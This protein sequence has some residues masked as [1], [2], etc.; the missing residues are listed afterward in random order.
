MA[1]P[2]ACCLE[3]L[4]ERFLLAG[5]LWQSLPVPNP[6][7]L[8]DQRALA[9]TITPAAGSATLVGIDIAYSTDGASFAGDSTAAIAETTSPHSTLATAQPLPE[10][11]A[12]TILGSF[13]A[14]RTPA[15]FQVP[16]D[17]GTSS[18]VMIGLS[19]VNANATGAGRLRVL[20]GSAHIL[21][22]QPLAS[23]P[24]SLALEIDSRSSPVPAA[25]YVELV[26]TGRTAAS[27]SSPPGYVL[28]AQSLSRFAPLSN[29]A[30]PTSG[31]T[32]SD[33]TVGSPSG[34]APSTPPSAGFQP[35][36]SVEQPAPAAPVVPSSPAARSPVVLP[37]PHVAPAPAGGIFAGAGTSSPVPGAMVAVVADLRFMDVAP[38]SSPATW[39][40]ISPAA[41][42]GTRPAGAPSAPVRMAA[43]WEAGDATDA[44]PS[45]WEM[46]DATSRGDDALGLVLTVPPLGFGVLAPSGPGSASALAVGDHATLPRITL[47][48]PPPDRPRDEPPPIMAAADPPHGRQPRAVLAILYGSVCSVVGLTAPDLGAAF[49]RLTREAQAVPLTRSREPGAASATPTKCRGG[50][51][52]DTARCDQS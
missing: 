4:E 21:V 34:G 41:V 19:W 22:D 2:L 42:P 8:V 29:D 24:L 44:G 38:I 49:R 28:S 13:G 26:P 51:P 14:V 40:T 46:S 30:P 10:G 11:V 52:R 45:R 33:T 43:R 36:L 17:A 48:P 25:L 3:I 35:V 37:L 50:W 32:G 20:D 27:R 18:V 7:E 47:S 31:P 12:T 39:A 15:V 5:V 9:G 1:R 23:A 16:L 6:P